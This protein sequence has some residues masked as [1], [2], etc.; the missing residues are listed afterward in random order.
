VWMFMF[1]CCNVKFSWS[2]VKQKKTAICFS[3]A[4]RFR[5]CFRV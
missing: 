2:R 5:V 1:P 4:H 3:L